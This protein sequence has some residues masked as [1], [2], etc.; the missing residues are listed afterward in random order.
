[1]GCYTTQNYFGHTVPKGIQG[2]QTSCNTEL[3]G[4]KMESTNT[5]SDSGF[6]E[7]KYHQ[8]V[9]KNLTSRWERI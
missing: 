8:Q 6:P 1:M 2:I 4:S 5:A 9:N 7:D 3:I